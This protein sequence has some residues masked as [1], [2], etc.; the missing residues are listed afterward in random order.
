M[1]TVKMKTFPSPKRAAFALQSDPQPLPTPSPSPSHPLNCYWSRP[2]DLPVLEGHKGSAETRS[3]EGRNG[4][5]MQADWVCGHR[6]QPEAP[7]LHAEWKPNQSH[8]EKAAEFTKD[9]AEPILY[10]WLPQ[11]NG[12]QTPS[13]PTLISECAPSSLTNDPRHE[14][15]ERRDQK[16]TKASSEKTGDS[17]KLGEAPTTSPPGSPQPCPSPRRR[18]SGNGHGPARLGGAR[19]NLPGR[20]AQPRDPTR[21]GLQA[22]RSGNGGV[23]QAVSCGGQPRA[24][25]S[26]ELPPTL[27]SVTLSRLLF[28]AVSPAGAGPSVCG[29]FPPS[30][31]TDGPT[32]TCARCRAGAAVDKQ[33][34]RS[35]SGDPRSRDRVISPGARRKPTPRCPPRR[36]RQARP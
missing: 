21:S 27:P 7:W 13:P 25:P 33:T 23:P 29:D 16:G 28:R 3:G 32:T 1:P 12:A 9:T 30:T 8:E 31:N 20:A 15:R 34:L 4:Q 35:R 10:W 22:P 18:Q 5:T 6:A 2:F 24:T 26:E 36:C 14:Y 19:P 11:R 17:A